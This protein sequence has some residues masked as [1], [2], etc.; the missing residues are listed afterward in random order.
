MKNIW[1]ALANFIAVMT[2]FTAARY[3][4]GASFNADLYG[5][6]LLLGFVYAKLH[7]IAGERFW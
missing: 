4:F 3:V 5:A 2:L 1:W 7:E 6:G